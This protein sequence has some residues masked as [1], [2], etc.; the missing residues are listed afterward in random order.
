MSVVKVTEIGAS[1]P[2]SFEDA[3]KQGVKRASKTLKHIKSVWIK[4]QEAE[5]NENG[6]IS[7][8]RVFMKITFVL[9]N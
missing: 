7:E 8:Y 4:E 9:E 6:E 2:N 3:V 1:S 5:L